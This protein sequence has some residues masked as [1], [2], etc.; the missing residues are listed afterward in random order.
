[1]QLHLDTFTK[2]SL[3]KMFRLTT[4]SK[5][6]LSDYILSADVWKQPLNLYDF[7]D[8][9]NISN[10][11]KEYAENNNK[12]LYF[13]D[14]TNGDIYQG[15]V[16][17]VYPGVHFIMLFYGQQGASMVMSKDLKEFVVFSEEFEANLISQ[18][19]RNIN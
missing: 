8:I 2:S 6:S 13:I 19:L 1:M 17:V 12:I 5:N 16:S 14:K 18:T 10:A 4:D 9:T 11:I 15:V 3:S 7:S